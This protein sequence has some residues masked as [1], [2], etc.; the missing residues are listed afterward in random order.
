MHILNLNTKEITKDIDKIRLRDD[1]NFIICNPWELKFVKED[2][3]LSNEDYKDLLSFDEKTKVNIYNNYIFFTLNK[4]QL[5]DEE[6]ILEEI[7]IFLSHKYLI[8]VLRKRNDIYNE[9]KQLMRESF[10]YKSDYTLSLFTIY[11]SIL[12]IIISNQFENLEMIEEKILQLE[13]EIIDE[14]G[15]NM[16]EKISD[17]R[18]VCRRC[19]KNIRPLT[20]IIDTLL[21][22]GTDYFSK[23]SPTNMNLEKEY[24]KLLKGLDL[25][26]DKLYNFALSTRELADKL[27]DIYSSK[28]SEKTNS[29][30]TKLTI[31]TGTAVPITMITGIYG[32]NFKYMPELTYVYGYKITIIII[33]SIVIISF[34]IFKRKKFL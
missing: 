26:I 13:D 29:L 18:S 7:N 11:S 3:N 28:V 32:M 2:L 10:Y 1:Y 33:I 31:L 12:R 14:T 9:V 25:S 24:Q 23:E 15:E 8:I 4:F 6:L 19:V 5:C 27:L 17:I 21:K 20:Y 22:S 16:S 30:I 34:I